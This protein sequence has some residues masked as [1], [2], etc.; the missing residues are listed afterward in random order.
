MVEFSHIV[1]EI[2]IWLFLLYGTAVALIYGWIGIYALGA[3]IRYKKENTFTDYSIIAADPNAPVFSLIAPAYNEGMTIVEN[4]RSLLSLYYHNLEIIIVNDGSKDDS[5]Q[6]LIDAYELECVHFFVQ[7]KIETN[8]IRGIYKS[9]NPA[10]KKLIIVDKENGGKADALNVGINVSSGE[11]LVCIDVDCILEQDSILKLAKPFLQQTDKKIIACGGVIRLANNCVIEDGK[12]V[13]VNMPRTLLGKIQAL[14]YIRAFVLGRMAWSRASGL[15][16]ISGA[17][18]V[19]DRK[20]VLACGGY[21]RNTVGEDMELVVRMRK[22][23][24]EQKTPYEVCTIPDPLCWT[25]VPES[26]DIL[27]KQRNRWMRGTMETLWK[28]R[29]LMFNPKYGKLGM[30]SLPYWF[31]FEFLG[32]L[33]EFLGYIVFIAFLLLGIINWS[34]FVI[35]FALVISLGFLYSIYSILVDLVSYQVYTKRKDFLTLIGTAF[36]EPFYFHPIV[37]KAGVNGFIDYFKKSHGWGEMKRQ[38]FNQSTENLPF[39][40]RIS[41]I[42]QNGLKKWGM[43]SVVFLLLFLV[44]ITAEWLWYRYS[45]PGLDMDAVLANLFFQNLLFTCKLI[46][47]LGIIYL[48]INFIKESWAKTIGITAFAFVVMMQYILFLYFSVTQN[49]LGAD[50]LYYTKDEIKQILASSGMLSFQNIALLIILAGATIIPLWIAGK[51]GFKSVYVTIIFFCLGLL[52]FFVPENSME[53]NE[54]KYSNTLTQTAGQSKWDY[55]FTSNE[56]NFINDYPEIRDIFESTELSATNA[57]TIDQAFPFWRKETTPDFLGPYFNQSSKAPNLVLVVLEGFG[58]A[59]TSP[60][61]YVGNFTPF[62]DSLS[63]K[64]LFWENNLSSAGRTFG[65]LP[66]LTGSLPFG[67]NGFLEIDKTPENFNLFNILK[68]N[69]F[70]TGFYYGGNVSFDRFKEFLDYSNVDHIVD[71]SSFGKQ[72]KRLPANNGESWG[73]EDQAVFNKMLEP[74]TVSERPYFNMVLTLSTHNPFLI[75]NPSYYEKLYNEKMKSNVLSAEQKKWASTFKNQLVSVVNADDAL[76]KFF[77]NYRKRKD[78]ENTIFIITGDHSMPEITLQSHIDRFHVPL[79][80]Y[81]PLLKEA[82]RFKKITSHFDVA[83][84]ILAYYRNNYKIKTPSTVAWLGR[85]FSSDTEI[86][87]ADIPVMQSKDKMIDFISGNYY[88]HDGQLFIINSS[89]SDAYRDDAVFKR[90]NQKFNQFKT[91]NSSFYATKKL[92]PDSVMINFKK[93]FRSK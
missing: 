88:L 69:G 54:S 31:F 74:K 64:S 51:S 12:V 81:S 65:S 61:G 87:K 75:N 82:K 1:Y 71:Q 6:K 34:F 32:P 42:L 3:V 40:T 80:I 20:I 93:K 27:K 70:E 22:Y 50:I 48:I 2:I 90:L 39:K 23:M 16:L 76:K 4:V 5:L 78:F 55:F 56:D 36:S 43:L 33:V 46:F 24:E 84:S 35:L 18:G 66:S 85:G 14:E 45:L 52:A 79:L 63:Q 59:Y 7:G 41:A 8:K 73:Y 49:T 68:A 44:G 11:Y 58:H 19:F 77:E 15:I 29:K 30:V 91:M 21:D 92:M 89:E 62:L 17:F 38:G 72:Y 37:V 28:H 53:F 26:K 67:K 57:E 10:F 25:E 83:P 60:K 47:G 9:K 86:G 13:S